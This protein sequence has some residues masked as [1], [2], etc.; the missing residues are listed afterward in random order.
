MLLGWHVCL[1]N[2]EGSALPT[3]SDELQLFVYGNYLNTLR[4]VSLT[5]TQVHIQVMVHI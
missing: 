2:A 5:Q 1:Q 4:A 3:P